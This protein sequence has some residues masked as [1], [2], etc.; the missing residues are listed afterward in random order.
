MHAPF[1]LASYSM[2]FAL[3]PLQVLYGGGDFEVSQFY[4]GNFAFQIGH[5]I[6]HSKSRGFCEISRTLAADTVDSGGGGLF[7]ACALHVYKPHFVLSIWVP[8][9]L[10][11]PSLHNA[12]VTHLPHSASDEGQIGLRS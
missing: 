4:V 6:S 9:S 7:A 5:G 1:A 8:L 12:G 11:G 3:V 10:G 2:H